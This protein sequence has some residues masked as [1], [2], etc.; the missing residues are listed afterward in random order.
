MKNTPRH[1]E[2]YNDRKKKN[3]PKPLDKVSKDLQRVRAL[4]NCQNRFSCH[5]FVLSSLSLIY[6]SFAAKLSLQMSSAHGLFLW[7]ITT[8]AG[9]LQLGPATCPQTQES[10]RWLLSR[11]PLNSCAIPYIW[12]VWNNIENLIICGQ[13]FKIQTIM[14]SEFTER[15]RTRCSSVR[16][17]RRPWWWLGTPDELVWGNSLSMIT[18]IP[19]AL[20]KRTECSHKP[21]RKT[22]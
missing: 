3:K 10:S 19:P 13:K 22:I 11:N 8:P 4:S 2:S 12:N 15:R 1:L 6:H 18:S 21:Y 20:E 9:L 16:C 17:G 14:L 5:I 7:Q